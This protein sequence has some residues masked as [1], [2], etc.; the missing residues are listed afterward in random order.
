MTEIKRV[1]VLGCGL[2]GSGIA[3]VAASAGYDTVV[4]DVS[5]EIWDRARAAIEKSLAK[6]VEKGKLPAASRD[7]AL[8]RL[9][10]TTATADLKGCDI[11]IEAVTED[12]ELKNALWRELDK[13]C[14]S[15]TIFA[16]NTSSLT[17]AAMAAAT[18]RGDRFVGLHFFNPVPLMPLVEV[19]RTVTTSEETF[20]RAFAFAK[21]LGKEP[22]AAKDNSGFIVNLLLVP[23]LLD[24]IRAVEHRVASVPDIDKAMQ[25][26]CG[27]PMGPLTLLDFVGLDT[28]YKIAEI[29]FTEYREPRYAPPPLLRRMVIAGMNGRKSG[30][31]FYDYAVDPPRVVDL[32]I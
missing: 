26:G 31:G 18:Q 13:L 17:I 16:S 30:K 1:G 32:G 14:G 19:V 27:Y 12:L 29:M 3:Q 2:M 25:L 24:A 7:A 9:A 5:K 21:S 28:T 15:D 10:F 11:V 6:F 4:R 23:Y 20:R 8:K 22:V